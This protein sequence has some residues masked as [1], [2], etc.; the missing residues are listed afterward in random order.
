M[1]SELTRGLRPM[2]AVL[3]LVLAIAAGAVG[4][5]QAPDA[6]AATETECETTPPSDGGEDGDGDGESDGDES[7]SDGAGGS[8]GS[9]EGEEAPPAAGAQAQARSA[10]DGEAECDEDPTDPETSPTPIPTAPTTE[11]V[12]DGL[13][14]TDAVFRWGINNQSNARSH[15]PSSINLLAAGLANPG[16]A[17][18]ELL[19]EDWRAKS[20]NVQIQKWRGAKKRWQSATWAGLSTNATGTKAIGAKGPYSNH[21]VVI[22]K[23]RG[24]VNVAKRWA[25]IAWTGTFSVVYYGG[26]A[27]FAVKDPVLE[28]RN[29]RGIVRADLLGFATDS[30]N[31]STG[32]APTSQWELKRSSGVKILDLGRVKLTNTG[33]TAT[34]RYL[35]VSVRNGSAT[36]FRAGKVWGSYPQEFIDFLATLGIHDQFWYSTGLA[37]DKTKLPLPVSV[38]LTAREVAPEPEPEPEQP[39]VNN[40]LKTPP[41][42]VGPPANPVQSAPS[43]PSAAV[44]PGNAPSLLTADDLVGARPVAATT[45]AEQATD[46]WI[47]WLAGSLTLIA[48]L[49]LLI[50]SQQRTKA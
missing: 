42:L 6:F 44:A 23:G 7:D 17:G 38:S 8:D 50:P 24:T 21:N 48:A 32:G 25:T 4:L 35:G 34:P 3:L 45:S 22:R 27:I 20:G 33:F 2:A 43:A 39:K 15:N 37:T 47:W 9:G 30:L 12:V 5:T 36:Q 41:P 18:R 31:P 10:A 29:G 46:G 40:S 11:P 49:A 16:K 14:V 1:R 13:E 19:A 28:V 26:N